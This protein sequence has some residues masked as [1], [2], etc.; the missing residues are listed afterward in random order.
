MFNANDQKLN[1]DSDEPIDPSLIWSLK[2]H[3]VVFPDT[4]DEVEEF[5]INNLA[6]IEPLPDYLADP[7]AIFDRTRARIETKRAWSVSNE[8][9]INMAMAAREGGEIPDDVRQQMER[10][11]LEALK[12]KGQ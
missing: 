2:V 4:D 6:S 7:M 11:R 3:G 10:D 12:K 1:Q 9:S 8:L 5:R